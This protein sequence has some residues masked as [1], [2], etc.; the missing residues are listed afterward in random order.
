MRINTKL[1]RVFSIYIEKENKKGYIRFRSK[2]EN[3]EIYY[4][5]TIVKNITDA[6]KIINL[7]NAKKKALEYSKKYRI[8]NI[9]IVDDK[10]MKVF[11]LN[12]VIRKKEKNAKEEKAKN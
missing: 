11:K 5:A 8:E 4:E 2:E 6:S 9:K 1:P 3:S 7:D 10:T 12:P